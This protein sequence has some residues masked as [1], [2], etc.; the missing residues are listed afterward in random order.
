MASS[1]M[2]DL[3]RQAEA[4][5]ISS[6]TPPEGPGTFEVVG[7][8]AS[9]TQK[10]DP[11]FGIQ[12]R[13]KGGPDDGKSFWINYNLIPVKNDGTPNSQ[14]L[15][16]TF[17][18]LAALGATADVVATWDVDAPDASE[19]VAAAV[20]GTV[21]SADVQ[22]KQSG[23]YTNVNLRKVKPVTPVPAAQPAAPAPDLPLPGAAPAAAPA[24]PPANKPF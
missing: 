18:D 14:G 1:T 8:N 2:A 9:K 10:G 3:L 4:A 23:D 11:K 12:F 21:I 19:Q 20:V 24:A 17:R 16:I 22:V 5:G 15:A 13:V 7:G 6:F